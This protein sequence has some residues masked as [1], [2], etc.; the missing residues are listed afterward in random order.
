MDI[1][2]YLLGKKAGGGGGFSANDIATRNYS[3]DLSGDATSIVMHAFRGSSI[4][5]AD[6]PEATS[7]GDYAFYGC[8]SLQSINIPKATTI[9][10]SAFNSCSQLKS[11]SFPAATTLGTSVFAYCSLLEFADIG[12]GVSSLPSPCFQNCSNKMILILRKTGGIVTIANTSNVLPWDNSNYGALYV[13]SALIASYK[14]DTNWKK[15]LVDTYQIPVYA[16]E[17]SIYE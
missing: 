10:F 9:A 4:T 15:Y 13:P 14:A 16:I 8:S 1:L 7:I 5:S 11:V 12:P 3:G 17:G 6:F 2:S